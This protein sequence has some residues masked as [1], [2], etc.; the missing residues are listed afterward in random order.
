MNMNVNDVNDEIDVIVVIVVNEMVVMD[1]MDQNHENLLIHVND[2]FF[3]LTM[4]GLFPVPGR[5]VS[6]S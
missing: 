6:G 4:M 2:S 1:V 3:V 5:S